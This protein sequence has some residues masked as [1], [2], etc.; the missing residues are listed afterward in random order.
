MYRGLFKLGSLQV[1]QKFAAVAYQEVG[2]LMPTGM[3][4]L[5][6]L[7][8]N[9]RI[10]AHDN[11]VVQLHSAGLLKH[12]SFTMIGPRSEPENTPAINT[13]GHKTRGWFVI[14]TLDQKYHL[15]VTWC[16]VDFLNARKWVVQLRRVEVNGRLIC[17]NQ[18]ALI[19]TGTS[20]L[21]TGRQNMDT[22]A[23]FITGGIT[24]VGTIEYAS[25]ALESVVF[26]FGDSEKDQQSFSL[27]EEDLSLGA[28][29]VDPGKLQ[30]PFVLLD[31]LEVTHPNGD[32]WV[33]G[34]IFLDN[35]ITIFD[36]IGKKRIGFAAKSSIDPEV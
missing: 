4:G 17:E 28:G 19:D 7:E 23:T 18:Q 6:F 25:N 2:P 33:L 13:E 1:E 14:G 35:I 32:Y 36:Y 5:G 30:S 11:L 21:G 34:G 27:N 12:A 16:Q 31:N 10:P 15:G 22:I 9:S 3:L 8:R 26:V 20:Y 24:N 29:V